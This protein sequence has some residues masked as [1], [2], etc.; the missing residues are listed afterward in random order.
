MTKVAAIREY[1]STPNHPVTFQEI[2]A[3]SPEEREYLAT[4]AAK[5]LG[6]EIS[7]GV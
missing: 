5:E 2:K 7:S 4:G 1:F 3:L 6:V